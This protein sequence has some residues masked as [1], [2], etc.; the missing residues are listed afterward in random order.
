MSSLILLIHVELGAQ[1]L[2]LTLPEP[3][4]RAG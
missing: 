3:F 4:A 2:L 1:S